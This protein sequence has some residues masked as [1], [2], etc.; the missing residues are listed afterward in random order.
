[1]ALTGVFSGLPA[2]S[3]KATSVFSYNTHYKATLFRAFGPGR[4]GFA[5]GTDAEVA[6]FTTT[7]ECCN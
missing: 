2:L 5:L 4:G 6:T 7:P 3:L 1:M